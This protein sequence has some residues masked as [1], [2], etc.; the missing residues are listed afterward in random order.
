VVGNS[1][2]IGAL[3]CFQHIIPFLGLGVL[4]SH[5]AKV[6]A[7]GPIVARV[8]SFCEVLVRLPVDCRKERGADGSRGVGFA[9]MKFLNK[10]V[11]V[12]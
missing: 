11:S 7:S 3:P 1:R 10:L 6:F 8:H 5:V 9:D 2:K 4:T 12:A